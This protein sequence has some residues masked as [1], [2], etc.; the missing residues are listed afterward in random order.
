MGVVYL[1]Q[2]GRLGRRVALKVLPAEF[3]LDDDRVARFELEGRVVAALNHPGVAVLYE[4][5]EIDG[6][7]YLAMEYVEGKGLHEQ[8][9]AGPMSMERLVDYTIQIADALEHAHRRG[10]L[11]RD[12]KPANIIVTLEGRVK[13]LD[14]GLARLLEAQDETR[15]GLTAPGTWMG[16]LQYCAPEVLRGWEADQRSDVYSLGVVLYQMV[17]GQLPF[18]GL[19]GHALVGAI[20]SGQPRG[21]KNSNPLIGADFHTF[22]MRA[23]ASD[24]NQRPQNVADFSRTLREIALGSVPQQHALQAAPVL[25][26]LDFQNITKD[27]SVDWL[28]TGLAETLTSDLKRLKLVKIVTRERVQ[29]AAQRHRLV[30]AGHSDVVELGKELGAHWVVLGSYQRSGERLRILPRVVEVA[31]GEETTT[32]KIDGCWEQVFAL[33]DRVVADVLSALEVRLDS[34]AMERIAPPETLHL[35]AYEQYAQGRQRLN[36]FGKESLERGRQHLESA[37]A[38]DP[39]YALAYAALGGTHAMRF[40]HRTDPADLVH[41]ARYLERAIELDPEL[42][43]PYPWLTYCYM[44]QGKVE[45]AIRTG[46][47]GVEAQPDLVLSHYFLGTSY[48]V[49]TEHDAAAYQSAARHFLDATLTDP[50][51]GAAWLCLGEIALASGE[52]DTAEQFLLKCL[53]AERRGPGFGYFIGAEM[54]LATVMHRSGNNDRARE[55]YS[56]STASLESCDHVYRE[57]MLALTA[58]G[59]GH[60][61]VR[62][63][64]AEAALTEFRRACRLVKEY[65]RML[66]RQR[67]LTR[68]LVGMSQVYAAQGENS[69]ARELLESGARSMTEIAGSPQTWLWAGS[70]AQLYY[71]L[72][73]AHARL[74][75]QD[76]ALDC[77]S[78]AIA[79]GWRDAHWL[80]SDPEF[81]R[82]RSQAGFQSLLEKLRLLPVLKF[83]PSAPLGRD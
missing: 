24:P 44:R 28:G 75:E 77:L 35:E 39:N 49:A 59:L 18:E 13:L 12:I 53:E 66:G 70:L 5:G 29:E 79:G 7:R 78:K 64:R 54:L 80:S 45:Q 46:H 21:A 58:C 67:V 26:V 57:A 37:V 17:C 65:P 42:G 41:A 32:A 82:L 2:D 1:A 50:R 40:I 38:L 15:S 34:S 72:S 73:A 33:Q 11:H 16:T 55:M 23:I 76:I 51:W 30:G 19:Q 56:G 25:A 83:Q 27:R 10:V 71:D 62:E 6:T 69:H 48:M 52:Y 3:A 60:L 63:G 61:L 47:K 31:T 43:E 8:C 20:L 36:E 22:I 68:A 4:I 81:I 14:F 9:A 74:G